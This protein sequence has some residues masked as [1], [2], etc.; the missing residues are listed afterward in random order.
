MPQSFSELASWEVIPK[1]QFRIHIQQHLWSKTVTM[2][3]GKIETTIQIGNNVQILGNL[4]IQPYFGPA[5]I[6]LNKAN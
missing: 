2:V 1:T 6:F 4:F 5:N 3:V